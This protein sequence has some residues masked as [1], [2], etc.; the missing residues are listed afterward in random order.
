MSHYLAYD[1]L[2]AWLRLA[3][4]EDVPLGTLR[5]WANSE[6]WTPHGTRRTR[7]WDLAEA[8]ATYLKYRGR[9][10]NGNPDE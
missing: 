2:R 10:Q 3:F 4:D 6:P 5:Y 7:R 9:P 8:R 1:E